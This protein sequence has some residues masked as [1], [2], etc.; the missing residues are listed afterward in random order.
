MRIK[1]IS[2]FIVTLG[3]VVLV[4][5][6]SFKGLTRLMITLEETVLPDYREDDIE[7]LLYHISEA[8]NNVRIYTITHEN[9]YLRPFYDN[10]EKADSL[11]QYLREGSESDLYLSQHL[12]TINQFLNRKT[13]IQNRIIRLKQDQNRIDVYE[14]VL[15]KIQTLERK[16]EV[17]DSL[18]NAIEKA[19][20]TLE[21]EILEK[22]RELD[23]QV[24]VPEEE[25]KKGF[26]K[27]LFKSGKKSDE[28]PVVE[29]VDLEKKS[30]E[31]DTLL[32]AKDTLINIIDT[33]KGEDIAA[34][35]ENTLA[36]I[37][38]R[39]DNINKELTIIE[40][41][42]TRRDK[43]IGYKIQQQIGLV[44]K[45]F[46]QLDV[47]QAEEAS[48]YFDRVTNLITVIGSIFSMLFLVL[49]FVV[50]NDIKVNQR[51]RKEMETAKNN[52]EKLAQAKEDF[53]SN[54]SHEIRTPMNAIL[55]FA[56]Q[57]NSSAL[58]DQNRKQ[59]NIIQNASKHLLSIIND[60][61]DYAKID[62]GKIGLDN[63]AFSIEENI[64][65][66]YDTLYQ[67]AA[68]KNLEFILET[69]ANIKGQYVVGDPVRFRQIIFNLTGNAIKFTEHG[70]VKISIDYDLENITIKVIDTGIGIE[71]SSLPLIFNKFDQGLTENSQKHGGTGLGL[72]IVKK[73]V[74]LQ[75]GTISVKS[76][77]GQGTE[78][79]VTLPLTPS[80]DEKNE[81]KK[82]EETTLSVPENTHILIVD[83][84]KFNRLLLET[85][86]DKFNI[87]HRSAGSGEEAVGL[88]RSESF[89]LV[90]IDLQMD[91]LNGFETTKILRE[92]DHSDV[93]IVAVTATATGDIKAKCLKTGMSDVLIK[94]ISE[95]DLL[96]CMQRTLEPKLDIME[97]VSDAN[98]EI[99]TNVTQPASHDLNKLFKLFHND[100]ALTINM[101]RIYLSGVSA[102][103]ANFNEALN[104]P[105][106]EAIRKTAHKI[107]PSSRHMGFNK[108]ADH[109]KHLELS[110][111]DEMKDQLEK[112]L[113]DSV[114]IIDILEKFLES[115]SEK[116]KLS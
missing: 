8:E 105:D 7:T 72:T 80:A 14:E 82:T 24:I 70:S 74:K 13:N 5:Y 38:I 36:E 65:I 93:P 9:R 96:T 4:G 61:L 73:L 52:A 92:Q 114:E 10:L 57:I 54:M 2:I 75:D 116:I 113:S 15:A 81:M 42:L 59:L 99:G 45:Y 48:N 90:L 91:G 67:N 63:I 94:P 100:K 30:R 19:E 106:F 26:F 47:G 76:E 3:A 27:R 32:A 79:C 31:L 44:Q 60:I 50:M 40:L 86:L 85:I 89:D 112:V 16:N 98:S 23:V 25:E 11:I 43:A 17:I 39:E 83:D 78:F 108:F 28:E 56:E 6:V 66:V 46:D 107:I 29:D 69:G 35:I 20:Q 111:E 18:K 88:F 21:N 34:E 49:I 68:D 77:K 51:Y 84:E 95:Y 115:A 87:S 102:A 33:L 58:N 62:A 71:E 1:L 110:Q 55:G 109:L 22:E 97:E 64:Q 41:N 103:V 104:H 37:K 53:L 12:D 101:T